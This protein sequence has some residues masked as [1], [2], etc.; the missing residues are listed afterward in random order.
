MNVNLK[1]LNYLIPKTFIDL[2][3]FEKYFFEQNDSD[4]NENLFFVKHKYG[5]KGK[6][7]LPLRKLSDI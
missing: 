3:S 4:K 6:S 2:N 1:N 7:V 5:V